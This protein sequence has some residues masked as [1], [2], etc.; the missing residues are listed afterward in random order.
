[1]T[2]PFRATARLSEGL[3]PRTTRHQDAELRLPGVVDPLEVV[4]PTRQLVQLIE[5][6]EIRVASP[7]LSHDDRAVLGI[8]MVQVLGTA[9]LGHQRPRQVRLAHL[10]RTKQE[11][12][13]LVEIAKDRL[14]LGSLHDS[15]MLQSLA[16]W[17]RPFRNRLRFVRF[18]RVACAMG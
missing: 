7:G 1:M 2:R 15:T 9:K 10:P 5:D 12:H 11:D 3:E 8:V 13:L 6:Q 4:L 18:A 16:V 17:S 14:G